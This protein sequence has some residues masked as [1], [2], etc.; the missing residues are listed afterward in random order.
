MA[1]AIDKRQYSRSSWRTELKKTGLKKQGG[2]P[3]SQMIRFFMIIS[4]LVLGQSLAIADPIS[5]TYTVTFS[6]AV[7]GDAPNAYTISDGNGGTLRRWTIDPGADSY[8]NEF[9]ERPTTQTYQVNTATP[10][11]GVSPEEIF[12]ATEV[13]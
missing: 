5:P 3:V 10:A 9:Y 2:W 4:V 12:A 1:I 8:Q 7:T 13:L 6:D 11:G